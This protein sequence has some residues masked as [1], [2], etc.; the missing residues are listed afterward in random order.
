MF[1][2]TLKMMMQKKSKE[3]L[4]KSMYIVEKDVPEESLCR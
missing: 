4:L 2:H 3:K 1:C